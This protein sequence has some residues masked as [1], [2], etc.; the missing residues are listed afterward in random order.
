[1]DLMRALARDY[2]IAASSI[3]AHEG[4]WE[5]D[6]FV[7][8]DVWFVK[9]WRGQPPTDLALLDDLASRG[10]PV[11]PPIRTLDGH[12][13]TT[14]YAVFPRVRASRALDDPKVLGRTLRQVHAISDV[15]LPRTPMDEWCVEFLRSHLDH[16]WI[17]ERR[18]ELAGAVDRL[19]DVADRARHVEAPFVL[20][21]NDLYGDNLLVDTANEVVA[22]VDWDHA[23]LAPREHDLWMLADVERSAGLLDAYGAD[24]LDPVHLEYAMLARALRDL[25]VRVS[26]EADRPGVDQWGFARIA[27][28]DEVLHQLR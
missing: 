22:I 14:T 18:N 9:V 13:A 8:D 7:V 1:M 15:D 16:P 10:L 26:T 21:H 28:V 23:C 17:A 2:G 5:A 12:L 4:G 24:H 27:R 25:A 3:R 6:C 11:A 19:E 20:V